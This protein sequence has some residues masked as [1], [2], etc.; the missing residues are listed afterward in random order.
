[1]KIGI[2]EKAVVNR[3]NRPLLVK[4]QYLRIA[5]SRK[6]KRWGFGRYYLLDKKGVVDKDVNI[7]RLARQLGV[8]VPR[9]TLEKYCKTSQREKAQSY[10]RR[11]L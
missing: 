8:V 10:S 4:G 7:E 5:D 1:M 3:L 9:K 6:Q 2:T 11:K